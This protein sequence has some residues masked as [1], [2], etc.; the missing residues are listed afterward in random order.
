M[1]MFPCLSLSLL[2]LSSTAQLPSWIQKA[3]CI[4]CQDR[5][6]GI[7]SHWLI[8]V[9]TMLYKKHRITKCI[10]VSQCVHLLKE[11][12]WMFYFFVNWDLMKCDCLRCEQTWRRRRKRH[13]DTEEIRRK[14]SC[15]ISTSTYWDLNGGAKERQTSIEGK[16]KKELWRESERGQRKRD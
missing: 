16:E 7:P 14:R 9:G 8:S 1:L 5:S 2:K 4:S 12:V 10:L 3:C 13:A 11:K 15:K 6:P